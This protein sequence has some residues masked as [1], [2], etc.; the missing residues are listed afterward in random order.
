[1]E[2]AVGQVS[3]REEAVNRLAA[4][5]NTRLSRRA[6]WETHR[7]GSVRGALSDE[8]A[9]S[10][11]SSPRS[12][13]KHTGHRSESCTGEPKVRLDHLPRL[14]EPPSRQAKN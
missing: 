5:A 9:Y 7:H 14:L 13:T 6:A 8:A 1:M 2:L 10:I 4:G 12:L 11:G 3:G